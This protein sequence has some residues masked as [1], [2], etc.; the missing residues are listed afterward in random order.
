MQK[1]TK[2][3]KR[4]GSLLGAM[5]AVLTGTMALPTL[6]E[7]VTLTGRDAFAARQKSTCGTTQQGKTRYGIFEGRLYSRMNGEKDRHL[8]DVLGINTRHCIVVED[9]ER[10]KGFRSISREIMVYLDKDTGEMVDTWE[11]PWTGK[12]NEIM[13]V[14]NDPV[15]MRG[16]VYEKPAEGEKP[17]EMTFRRYGDIA[18][19]SYEVPLFY[20]NPLGGKY[21][22][23]VGGTYHAMEIFNTY[24][25]AKNLLNRRVK[26]VGQSNIGWSR[27]A[28]WLPFLEMGNREGWMIFNATGFSTFKKSEIPD[29]LM[30][31]LEEKYPLY[32]TP[33]PLDDPRP[34]ETTWTVFKDKLEAQAGE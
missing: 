4:S 29:N 26:D 20:E 14:A 33:P 27:V 13:H 10:G 18:V 15:N 17:L 31:I 12:T 25:Q 6:A 22:Q 19:S 5:S 11:N 24:Y 9:E 1:L 23:Y 30:K 16:F 2:A 21:Q 3:L 32:L 8:F 7:D 34:N 28:Q